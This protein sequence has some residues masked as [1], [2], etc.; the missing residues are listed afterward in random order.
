VRLVE[1]SIPAGKRG[2]VIGVLQDEGI[3]YVLTEETGRREYTHVVSFPVPAVAVEPV[4]ERIREL[5]VGEDSYTIV[6]EPRAVT[7]QQYEELQERYI[8]QE[9]GQEAIARDELAETAEGNVSDFRTYLILTTVSAVIATAGLLLDSPATVVGSMVIA[10]LIGPAM[11]TAVGSVIDDD[12]LFTRG[13]RMQVLGMLLAVVTAAAFAFFV[14][15][16]NLVPPGLEPESLREIEGRLSPD[17]LSLAVALG[18]GV[19]GALS[20]TTGVSAALVG[21]M[22][23]VAL[24]PPAATV[25]IGMA[26]GQPSIAIPSAILA[27]VNWLSINLAAL[28]VLW[29]S[30]YRPNHILRRD[31]ARSATIK[32]AA[33]L[34]VA[35]ALLS[36]FLGGI[37]LNT[38]QVAQG[39][40]DI[41]GVVESTLETDPYTEATLLSLETET[42]TTSST[43]G[44]TRASGVVVTVGVPPGWEYRDLASRLQD[45]IEAETGQ[46]MPVE[47]HYVRVQRTEAGESAAVDGERHVA[48][49]TR[50][51]GSSMR[52]TAL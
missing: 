27:T 15:T 49:S 35:I 42:R 21:V 24:V 40:D 3:D 10:P 23:A 43:L 50:V 45:R 5:G 19:A 7:S 25:G 51:T 38:Y 47:V 4:L 41:R 36:V 37:T 52:Q 8:E 1:V 26:Y 28:A 13:V 20:L 33:V 29:Y 39:E 11:S 31:E 16:T 17:F 48:P 9:G 6:M 18:A 14:R 30:G 12:E 34:V 46:S 32:R 44:L 22:I 2:A